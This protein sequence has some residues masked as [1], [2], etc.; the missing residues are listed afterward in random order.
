MSDTSRRRF[1]G[2]TGAGAAAVGASAFLPSSAV[3]DGP[4]RRDGGSTSPV[5]AYV[6]DATSDEVVLMV[7]EREVVVRDR[8]LVHRLLDAAGR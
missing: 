8:D 4:R 6:E 1:I 2:V 5:V 7:D 3:A